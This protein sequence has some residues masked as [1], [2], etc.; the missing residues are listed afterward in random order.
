MSQ[1]WDE[2]NDLLDCC[3]SSAVE[4]LNDKE[5]LESFSQ[6]LKGNLEYPCSFGKA[7][8]AMIHEVDDGEQLVMI[9]RGGW[10][11][12]LDI[13]TFDL[14]RRVKDALQCIE[15]GEDEY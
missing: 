3:G 4:L 5:K 11:D 15:T 2:V 7:C 9:G 1:F 14:Q 6:Q 13:T 10:K 12:H 8:W